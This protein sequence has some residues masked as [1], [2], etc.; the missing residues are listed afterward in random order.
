MA[1]L[2]LLLISILFILYI[3][4]VYLQ[5]FY[6]YQESAIPPKSCLLFYYYF[7]KWVCYLFIHWAFQISRRFR[8]LFSLDREGSKIALTGT[9]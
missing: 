8:L 7:G 9:L 5:R 3:S 6:S 1:L 2:L 4:S